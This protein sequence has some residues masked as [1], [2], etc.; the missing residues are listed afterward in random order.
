MNGETL[1]ALKSSIRKWEKIVARKE[2][3]RG[4]DNCSLCILFFRHNA[5]SLVHPCSGCP[6]AEHTGETYCDGTPYPDFSNLRPCREPADL[7]EAHI[8]AAR[9]ELDFLKSLLPERENIDER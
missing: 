9:K 6:V 1:E 5:G 7:T 3:N 4:V 8:E 2:I